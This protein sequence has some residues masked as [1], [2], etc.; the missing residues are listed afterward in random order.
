M[1]VSFFPRLPFDVQKVI[2]RSVPDAACWRAMAATCRCWRAFC[3]DTTEEMNAQ[4]RYRVT[5]T[6]TDA[7]GFT[8][9]LTTMPDG[10]RH[11]YSTV[12]WSGS[13]RHCLY[14]HGQLYGRM[15]A[16]CSGALSCGVAEFMNG[17]LH[18]QVRLWRMLQDERAMEMPFGEDFKQDSPS[19]SS[20]FK[21]AYEG[22]WAEDYPVG[23]HMTY[24][25]GNDY[26]ERTFAEH[27]G[28]VH[29]Q[30]VGTSVNY[31]EKHGFS[32]IPHGMQAWGTPI[33]QQTFCDP[34]IT[35]LRLPSFLHLRKIFYATTGRIRREEK[36]ISTYPD[37]V[38]TV[39]YTYHDNGV[40]ARRVSP[41]GY[42]TWTEEGELVELDQFNRDSA[43][44][45]M[46]QQHR[47]LSWVR[48]RGAAP[49]SA[50]HL[51]MDL[52]AD[53]RTVVLRKVATPNEWRAM[54]ATCREMRKLC[55]QEEAWAKSHLKHPPR[56]SGHRVRRR[57][58]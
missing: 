14:L 51:F 24:H 47:H 54:G 18:G 35:T 2:V 37:K 48:E 13:G 26:V 56:I 46:C 45:L 16:W 36:S 22:T 19:P 42:A 58:Y 50:F 3:N 7:D 40:L 33:E 53:L 9:K 23:R 17:K 20:E 5:R 1:D 52:P 12:F 32:R 15:V 11:G 30:M 4:W 8:V 49:Y 44:C 10:T 34:L 21:L 41:C 39:E 27:P 29:G 55:A 31:T 25:K 28:R 6:T 43:S 57:R 38:T